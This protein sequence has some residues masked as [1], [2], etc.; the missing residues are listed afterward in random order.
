MKVIHLRDDPGDPSGTD[1]SL[2]VTNYE[3]GDYEG[4]GYSYGLSTDGGKV[5]EFQ[6]GHCSCFG[7]W[8]GGYLGEPVVM[9]EYSMYAFRDV[10]LGEN[11]TVGTVA[12]LDTARRFIQEVQREAS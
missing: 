7:P 4:N 12:D 3:R 2:L 5:Y 8:E 1:L 11:V 9:T 10:V 6:H